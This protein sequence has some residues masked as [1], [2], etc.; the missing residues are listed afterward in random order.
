MLLSHGGKG[1]VNIGLQRG[2]ERG[3]LV[4]S[5]LFC[6][7]RF[8]KS[9]KK[10]LLCW[11]GGTI[12]LRGRGPKGPATSRIVGWEFPLVNDQPKQGKAII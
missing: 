6:V 5:S 12:P 7:A 3:G 10:R 1:A 4:T 11:W 8:R 2:K 9:G